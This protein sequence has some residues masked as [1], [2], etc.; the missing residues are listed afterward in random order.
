VIE[1]YVVGVSF[2]DFFEVTVIVK[3]DRADLQA[4]E[5]GRIH[6]IVDGMAKPLLWFK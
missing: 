3:P 1:S 5:V 4:G 2:E 6:R